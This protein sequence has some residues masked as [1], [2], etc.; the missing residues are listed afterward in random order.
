[1]NGKTLSPID[2]WRPARV[3]ATS[4]PGSPRLL[5]VAAH[6]DDESMAMG[7]T[8]ARYAAEGVETYVL[9]A[10][11][12]ERGRYRDNSDHPGPEALGRI[13]EAELR[14]AA[15]EL[16]VRKVRLLDYVDG[17]L[18]KAEPEEASERIAAYIREV[19]PDVVITFGPEGLYGHPDHIAI[20]QLTTAAVLRAASPAWESDFPRPH[21][22]SKLY[23]LA[24]S[25]RA[26]DAFE[27]AYKKV[28]STVDGLVRGATP[29]RDWTITTSIDARPWWRVVWRAVRCHT[30][31][32][33]AF[34]RLGQSPERV[35]E[36][37]W[38]SQ[39]YY[40]AFS[41]VNGGRE[42]ETDLFAGLRDTLWEHGA[43]EQALAA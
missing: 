43:V 29:W 14:A 16:G 1:M 6:P 40:R 35:H 2:R 24:W 13:R 36:S 34:N 32:V 25:E 7:G 37:V 26:L 41:L 12:G 17:E 27:A 39:E 22:V 19:R 33:D 10:T 21:R 8:L 4:N 23:Y 42:P 3:R 38:G 11:R 15:R 31:Q 20:S 9:T 5:C 28:T 30:S 18:D